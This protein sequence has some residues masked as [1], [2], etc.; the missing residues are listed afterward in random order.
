MTG[1]ESL[2]MEAALERF[3]VEYRQF[4]YFCVDIIAHALF[5]DGPVLTHDLVTFLEVALELCC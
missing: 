5:P 4:L 2:R 3:Q 1:I